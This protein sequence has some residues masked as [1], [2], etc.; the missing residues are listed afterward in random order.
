MQTQRSVDEASMLDPTFG[1]STVVPQRSARRAT[2]R[3][4]SSRRATARQRKDDVEGRIDEYVQDHP[5]ST[6]GDIAKRLNVNRGTIA[7]ERS[8]IVRA[9]DISTG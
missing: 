3:R 9:G 8:N 4:A 1:T 2:A 6:I 5:D 7:A